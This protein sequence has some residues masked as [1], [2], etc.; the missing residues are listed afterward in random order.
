MTTDLVNSKSDML[1]AL[2][3]AQ[4]S[5]RVPDLEPLIAASIRLTS[6]PTDETKLAVGA[7]KLGGSPDLSPGTTWPAWNKLPMSFIAQLDLAH[8]SQFDVSNSLPKTGLLTFFYDS[9]QQDFG[10]DP[11]NRGQWQV[12]LQPNDPAQLQRTAL[13]NTLPAKGRFKPCALQCATEFTLPLDVSAFGL[14]WAR[15][16]LDR[17]SDF[18]TTYPTPGDRKTVHHR[19]LG[20]TNQIQDDMHVQVEVESRG[21]KP[22]QV[23]EEM[24]R[25]ALHWRLLLQV[26]TDPQAGMNWA[27]NG[28]LYLWIRERDLSAQQFKNVWLVLQSE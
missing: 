15:S 11:A 6:Q 2:S 25:D 13:P 14:Q 18:M 19:L 12:M 21:L 20:H 23:T 8:L 22:D 7:T 26:D 1:A 17:Y 5:D 24:R 9:N 16:D 4:L 27:N 10:S 3:K 28:M